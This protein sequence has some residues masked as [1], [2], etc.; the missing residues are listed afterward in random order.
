M[1]GR[2]LGRRTLLSGTA[3]T[4]SAVGLGA[5]SNRW[6]AAAQGDPVATPTAPTAAG[7]SHHTALVN[8]LALHYVRAG[9]GDPVVLLHG[10]PGF[11]YQWRKVIP[12]LADRFDVIVPDMRGYG[13]SGKPD[14]PYDTRTMAQDVFLL[15]ESLGL[16]PI[17]LAGWDV[18]AA[19]AYAYAAN[20]RASVRR[21]AYLDEP[22][23]GFSYERYAAFSPETSIGGGFWWAAF[24]M[25]SD[26]PEALVSGR[27]ELYLSWFFN[28]LSYDKGAI[29]R[30]DLAEYVRA[31]AAAGTMRASRGFYRDVFASSAQNRESAGETLTIPVLAIGGTPPFATGTTPQ[32]DMEAV[33]EDVRGLVFAE[34]GHFLPEEKPAELAAELIAFFREA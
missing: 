7:W 27:E 6:A 15:A 30:E 10:W 26:L 14:G 31:Y 32:E 25:V 8:G 20:H 3:A 24:H 21:L 34:C 5:A 1:N 12:L 19:V 2:G 9:Q 4:A 17:N 13:D 16:G 29:G 11:W 18:G 23:P 28:R 22:L 33:A